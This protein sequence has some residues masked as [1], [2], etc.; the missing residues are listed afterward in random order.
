VAGQFRQEG[1]RAGTFPPIAKRP[2]VVPGEG[3]KALVVETAPT[4]PAIMRPPWSAPITPRGGTPNPAVP[5]IGGRKPFAA[6]PKPVKSTAPIKSGVAVNVRASVVTGDAP[7]AR[8][9]PRVPLP[10]T[11]RPEPIR[12]VGFPIP[13]GLGGAGSAANVAKVRPEIPKTAADP[14]RKWGRGG[15]RAHVTPL[16]MPMR[17]REIASVISPR[18]TGPLPA[19]APGAAAQPGGVKGKAAGVG[20]KIGA[21]PMNRGGKK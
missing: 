19:W 8:V 13:G 5:G 11:K 21:A 2:R 9:A 6:S 4:R 12:V 1:F 17:T 15:N 14:T 3:S 10:G 18:A 7:P 16:P 20:F